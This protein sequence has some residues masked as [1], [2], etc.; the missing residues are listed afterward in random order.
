MATDRDPISVDVWR[1]RSASPRDRYFPEARVNGFTHVDGTVAFYIQ[2]QGLID[3]SSVVL[4]FGAGRGRSSFDAAPMRREL[5]LLRGKAARVIGVDVDAAIR[6]NADLD[7]AHVIEDGDALPLDDE[8]IDVVVADWVLEHIRDP[9]WAAGELRRVLKPGG[10]VCARTPNRWGY[11]A[12]SGRLV[13]NGMHVGVLKVL[14][15]T[16]EAQDTFPTF[17][18][19]NDERALRRHFPPT[20]FAHHS[21]TMNN[22][23]AYVGGS[24]FMWAVTSALHAVLPRRLGV[25][26]YELLQKC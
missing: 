13:P 19:L 20:A 22:E 3:G 10:W 21:F 9:G 12:L 6:S 4:N 24:R 17:F 5:Q 15:P 23:P 2:V 7:E 1:A 8:S 26:R 11:V 18:R 25:T 16:K 14:Q